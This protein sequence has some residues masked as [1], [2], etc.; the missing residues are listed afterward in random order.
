MT[1][2]FSRL[3]KL[4]GLSTAE[5]ARYLGVSHDT[6]KSWSS[7]RNPTPD[8]VIDA[9]RELWLTIEQKAAEL[10][11]GVTTQIELSE[12]ETDREAQDELQL[13]SVSAFNTSVA[14]VVAKSDIRVVVVPRDSMASSKEVASPL[15][16]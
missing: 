9:L 5:A 1:T 14:L 13:P 6:V 16:G 4:T 2:N 8:P 15:H 3:L 10:M 12:P 11:T 7:G